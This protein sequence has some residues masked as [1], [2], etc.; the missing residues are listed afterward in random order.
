LLFQRAKEKLVPVNLE[1]Y[2]NRHNGKFCAILT[3]DT[4]RLIEN[5]RWRRGTVFAEECGFTA[6][7]GTIMYV[8]AYTHGWSGGGPTTGKQY[9][10]AEVTHSERLRYPTNQLTAWFRTAFRLIDT[11]YT[12][13]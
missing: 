3:T 1:E 12:R 13:G 2:A 10:L 5:A 11:G 6:P 9:A 4:H 8:A 7:V